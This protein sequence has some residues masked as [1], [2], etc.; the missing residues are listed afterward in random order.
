M[1]ITIGSPA[2]SGFGGGVVF[3]GMNSGA[4]ALSLLKDEFLDNEPEAAVS[5]D[6][7]SVGSS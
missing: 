5:V 1:I 7:E 3:L 6:T 4:R 2:L